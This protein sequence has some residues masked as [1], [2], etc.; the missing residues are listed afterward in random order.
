M[1]DIYKHVATLQDM[2]FF[3]RHASELLPPHPKDCA[4][5]FIWTE[6]LRLQTHLSSLR[7]ASIASL[8]S[9]LALQYP[10]Q[11]PDVIRDLAGTNLLL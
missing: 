4:G 2:Q 8:S 11:P 1:E 7:E 6:I 5:E 3:V 9:A 10:E